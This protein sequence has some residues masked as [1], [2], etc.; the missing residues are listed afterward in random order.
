MLA[1]LPGQLFRPWWRMPLGRPFPA[2]DSHRLGVEVLLT[3][4]TETMRRY[5]QLAASLPFQFGSLYVPVVSASSSFGV[6]TV[7]R[8]RPRTPPTYCRTVTG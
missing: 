1:G 7:L 4:A 3:D 6:L 8:P 2:A 5:P